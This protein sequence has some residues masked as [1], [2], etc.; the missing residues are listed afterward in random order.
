MLEGPPK[1]TRA[2]PAP[3]RMY[4]HRTR[5]PVHTP[6]RRDTYGVE[7][8]NIEMCILEPLRGEG[9]AR[10]CVGLMCLLTATKKRIKSILT[11]RASLTRK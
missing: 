11:D 2:V 6:M 4:D 1:R 8:P 7:R 3:T 5:C 9:H 10:V